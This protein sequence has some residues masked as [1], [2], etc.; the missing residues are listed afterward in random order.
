MDVRPYVRP[1]INS[2]LPVPSNKAAFLVLLSNKIRTVYAK[3]L[4][5]EPSRLHRNLRRLLTSSLVTV[6]TTTT[7]PTA[8]VIVTPRSGT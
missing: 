3:G 1:G 2:S 5:A 4:A 6:A 8:V 7:A